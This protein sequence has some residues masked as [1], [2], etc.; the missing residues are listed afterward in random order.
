[1]KGMLSSSLFASGT[2]TGT[3]SVNF[4]PSRIHAYI[5]LD[6]YGGDGTSRAGILAYARRK[7]DNTDEA[8]VI[9][10]FNG[11]SPPHFADDNVTGIVYQIWS[12]QAYGEATLIVTFW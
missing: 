12:W 6:K 2:S 11:Y 10:Q 8:I 3:L 7:P 1:M 4:A 5:A 9:G